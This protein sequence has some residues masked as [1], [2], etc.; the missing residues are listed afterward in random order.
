M[1]HCI[2]KRLIFILLQLATVTSFSQIT[3]A[4]DTAGTLTL[5]V[6]ETKTALNNELKIK[7][8]SYSHEHSS[9]SPDE[10]FSA[11]TGV[12][13]FEITSGNKA[14]TITIYTGVSGTGNPVDWESYTITLLSAT[15]D[16][17]EVVVSVALK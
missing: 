6:T 2:P 8:S 11:G 1:V 15:P 17:R 13:N 5:K 4:M 12:Y 10:P 16:Q 7:Y 14:G 9:S 3:P